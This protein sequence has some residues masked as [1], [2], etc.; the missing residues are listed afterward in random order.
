MEIVPPAQRRV[1]SRVFLTETGSGGWHARVVFHDDDSEDRAG[2]FASRA[3]A[4]RW[5]DGR[6]ERHFGRGFPGRLS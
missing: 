6:L 2:G 5:A 4:S 3:E 1:L